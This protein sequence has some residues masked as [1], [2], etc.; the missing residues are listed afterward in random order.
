MAS[1]ANFSSGSTFRG[2]LSDMEYFDK[3][4][5]TARR[6]LADAVFDWASGAVLNSWKRARR[7]YK[8]GAEVAARVSEWD[9]KQIARDCKKVW[10]ENYP[11][12]KFRKQRAS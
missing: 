2:A 9:A 8:S 5:P 1:N 12:P 4:P 11:P 3:L 7:G 6:A 10:G